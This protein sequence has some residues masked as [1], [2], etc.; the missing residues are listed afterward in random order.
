MKSG[1]L[2]FVFL[3]TRL[4]NGGLM[5]TIDPFD[6]WVAGMDSV[7]MRFKQK[8]NLCWLMF[9]NLGAVCYVTV[10]SPILTET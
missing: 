10:Y 4:L 3:S 2:G 8:T 1:L 7:R 6:V 5:V 9:Q